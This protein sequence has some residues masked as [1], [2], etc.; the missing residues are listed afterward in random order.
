MDPHGSS[1]MHGDFDYNDYDYIDSLGSCKAIDWRLLG[2]VGAVRLQNPN[3]TGGAWAYSVSGT[4]ESA[5]AI[6]QCVEEDDNVTPLS[7]Q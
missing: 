1:K 2:K 5:F 6:S 3:C 4:L 7:V